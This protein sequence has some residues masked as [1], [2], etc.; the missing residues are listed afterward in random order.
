MLFMTGQSNS[1]LS[2]CSIVSWACTCGHLVGISSHMVSEITVHFWPIGEWNKR[3]TGL[4]GDAGNVNP[5][6]CC[7]KEIFLVNL[8]Q[9]G[10]QIKLTKTITSSFITAYT[11]VPGVSLPLHLL[12]S[13]WSCVIFHLLSFNATG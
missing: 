7:E 2:R 3:R 4:R 12:N 9:M 1:A 13:Q 5:R 10:G 6:A 11:S 8:Q